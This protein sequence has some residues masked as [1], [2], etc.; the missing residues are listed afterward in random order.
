MCYYGTEL[1]QLD[2][3]FA[4]A[5]W[6]LAFWHFGP[7]RML[8]ARFAPKCDE[9]VRYDPKLGHKNPAKC[10]QHLAT[11]RGDATAARTSASDFGD[12]NPFFPCQKWELSL[13]RNPSQLC[14]LKKTVGVLD[15]IWEMVC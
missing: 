8:M 11:L 2:V 14:A 1:W 9:R 4:S 3:A 15:P 7:L 10:G 13:A 5:C 12:L 6:Q